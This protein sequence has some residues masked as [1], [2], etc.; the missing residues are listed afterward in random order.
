MYILDPDQGGTDVHTKVETWG[1]R[2]DALNGR[3][4]LSL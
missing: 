1:D 3:L 4:F 2:N